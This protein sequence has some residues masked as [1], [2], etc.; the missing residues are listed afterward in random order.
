M[1]IVIVLD[2]K[3]AGLL[4]GVAAVEDYTAKWPRTPEWE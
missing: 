1:I 3:S 4:Q 2:N